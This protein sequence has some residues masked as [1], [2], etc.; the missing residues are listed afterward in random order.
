MSE[1]IEGECCC[2][3]TQHSNDD[4]HLS[5]HILHPLLMLSSF[6]LMLSPFL[7]LTMLEQYDADPSTPFDNLPPWNFP[8][9]P[10]R[11]SHLGGKSIRPSDVHIAPSVGK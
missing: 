3:Q 9:M 10:R 4:D 1:K 6:L 2:Q 7:I 8:L 5:P 11:H